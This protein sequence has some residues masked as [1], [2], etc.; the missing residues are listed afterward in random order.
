MTTCP[1]LLQINQEA[2]RSTEFPPERLRVYRPPPAPQ[3]YRTPLSGGSSRGASSAEDTAS[4]RD[5]EVATSTARW[6]IITSAKPVVGEVFIDGPLAE[7]RHT[8]TPVTPSAMS[9]YYP[10]GTT[11]Q[12]SAAAAFFA[13]WDG[14]VFIIILMFGMEVLHRFVKACIYIEEGKT[15]QILYT[16]LAQEKL[17]YECYKTAVVARKN[18]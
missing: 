18:W 4:L 14:N 11:A 9:P 1:S 3:R 12:A 5:M 7:P 10:V 15:K 17:I 13:R 8:T 2:V 16:F 6:Q